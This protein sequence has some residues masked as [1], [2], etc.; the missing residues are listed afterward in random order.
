[1]STLREGE[2]ALLA[3]REWR[4]D[5]VRLEGGVSTV[6]FSP[7]IECPKAG[8]ALREKTR[9]ERCVAYSSFLVSPS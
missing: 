2:D 8:F 4:E 5:A 9:T 6:P 1:L 7:E 3:A